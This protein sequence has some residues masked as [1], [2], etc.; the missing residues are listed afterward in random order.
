METKVVD[1]MPSNFKNIATDTKPLNAICESGGFW[2][3]AIN[4]IWGT[5]EIL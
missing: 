4:Y 2:L 3:I 5:T 1:G